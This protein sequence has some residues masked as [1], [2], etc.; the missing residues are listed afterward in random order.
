MYPEANVCLL[1]TTVDSLLKLTFYASVNFLLHC[2]DSLDTGP[3]FGGAQTQR[4]VTPQA[5]VTLP[6]TFSLSTVQ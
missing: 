4:K 3:V 2:E 5:S 1:N 6:L